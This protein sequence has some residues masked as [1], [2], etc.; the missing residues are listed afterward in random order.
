LT[1]VGVVDRIYTDLATLQ[2]TAAGLLIVDM[3]DGLSHE[4]LEELT[5]ITLI[6]NNK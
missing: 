2:R 5:N 1:G 3:V 6:R 4:K